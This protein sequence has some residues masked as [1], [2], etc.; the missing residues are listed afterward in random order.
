[1]IELAGILNLKPVAEG[2]ERADQLDRLMELKCDLG[3][4]YFFARPLEPRGVAHAARGAQRDARR[5]RGARAGPVARRPSTGPTSY[6]RADCAPDPSSPSCWPVR[7]SR[8]S[9]SRAG[10]RPALA[11]QAARQVASTA[12]D[13]QPGWQDR[14]DALI[15]DRRMSVTIGDDGAFWYRHLALVR[16]APASNEK[17]LLSMALLA[18][19]GPDRVIQTRAMAA[20][21]PVEGVIDGDLWLVGHGDPELGPDALMRSRS[22][23]PPPA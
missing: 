5:G 22:R 14:I 9:R 18:A 10:P 17:L 3:Q 7:S 13:G 8:A 16:R 19:V 4:G 21:A 20:A 2:I 12:P 1:M 23:S 11:T 15:G 6:H